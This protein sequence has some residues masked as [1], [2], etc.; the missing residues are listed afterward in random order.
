MG[1][2]LLDGT[3]STLSDHFTIGLTQTQS[4]RYGENPHQKAGLYAPRADLGPLGGTLLQGKPLS[5]N[6][7]LDASA[8]YQA[9][10]AFSTENKAAVVIIKHMNP[11][12]IAV[13]DTIAE[14]MPQAL[15]SDP[16]SAFGG[17]IAVNRQVD[18]EFVRALGGL[19]VEV[20]IAPAFT[21]LYDSIMKVLSLPDE[22]RLFMCHDY[23]PGGREIRWETT[24]AEEKA[25]NIHVGGG[26]TREDFI[27]FRSERDAQLAMPRLIVPS[28]QANIRAG[29]IPEDEDGNQ[30][31]R[32]PVNKL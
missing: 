6:N 26:K 16:V 21:T 32:V 11:T 27:K 29:H 9:V 3:A 24:V 30:V 12:G 19:F 22:T 18:A 17:I 14:A 4:L 28:I 31:I 10:S 1:D 5:Y 13:A 2:T 8:A 20:V 23:A 25:N 15:S 7:L